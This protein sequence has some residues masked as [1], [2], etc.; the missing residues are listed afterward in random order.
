MFIA[1]A[2]KQKKTSKKC[3][4]KVPK[5]IYTERNQIL[6][7]L[8]G[9]P[10]KIKQM[11]TLNCETGFGGIFSEL[12]KKYEVFTSSILTRICDDC[13]S[14]SKLVRPLLPV[15]VR[16]LDI[17]HL[18]NYIVDPTTEDEFCPQCK[19]KCVAEH[20]INP[21]LALEVEPI[22]EKAKQCYSVGT[23]TPRINVGGKVYNLRGVVEAKPNERHF[24]C[25]ML[26][27]NQV[28]ETFDNMA[29]NVTTLDPLKEIKIF[30]LSYL[31]SGKSSEQNVIVELKLI[32]SLY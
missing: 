12:C 32:F 30:M 28:W 21:I 4:E 11:T 13:E 10:G 16:G 27:N 31:C 26:R 24:I 29:P 3:T 6:Y 1:K 9:H 18:Q 19:D 14:A 5:N 25:H 23:I 17:Q 15:S 7:N 8:A 2:M 20:R 22:S